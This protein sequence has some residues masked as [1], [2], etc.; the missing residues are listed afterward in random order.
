MYIS[1]QEANVFADAGRHRVDV[2]LIVGITAVAVVHVQ[3]AGDI[4]IE[5]QHVVAAVVRRCGAGQEIGAVL[6]AGGRV[7]VS[8]GQRQQVEDRGPGRVDDILGHDVT[9]KGDRK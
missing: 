7:D 5:A 6:L 2:V 1:G 8:I 9:G 4:G 3:P